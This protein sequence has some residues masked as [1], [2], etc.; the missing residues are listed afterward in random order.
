LGNE[1]IKTEREFNRREWMTK[2]PIPPRNAVFDVPGD[3]LDAI[4]EEIE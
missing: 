2:E 1:T 3:E 4:F